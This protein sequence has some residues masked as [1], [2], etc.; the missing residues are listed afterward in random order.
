LGPDDVGV[1]DYGRR[2]VP[3]L[4]REELAMLAGI[5]SNY[6]A[7]LEQG[8]GQHPSAQVIDALARALQLDEYATAHLHAISRAS[9]APPEPGE[10][11]RAPASIERLIASWPNTPAFVQNRFMDVLAA[12]D[13][14]SAITPVLRPGQNMVRATFL[15]PVVRELVREWDPVA[16]NAVARLRAL[17]GPDGDHPR[18]VELVEELSA[19]DQFRRLWERHDVQEGAAPKRTIEHPLVGR[20]ELRPDTLEIIGT[21][22]QL[23][24]IFQ[25]EPGPSERALARL[26]EIVAGE[27]PKTKRT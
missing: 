25:A 18:L 12:N 15:D 23:L 19:N 14:A 21:E 10:P 3:G 9:A 20:L 27:R 22:G 1:P 2:R 8:R 5:S 16:H 11:E 7:R 26:A 24:V 13:L 4:R 6:Y 17:V